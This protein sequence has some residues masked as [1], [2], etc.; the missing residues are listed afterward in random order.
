MTIGCQQWSENT[1]RL[2]WTAIL[3]T[4][5]HYWTWWWLTALLSTSIVV[6]STWSY[7]ICILLFRW[8]FTKVHC[9]LQNK[10]RYTFFYILDMVQAGWCRLWGICSDS[11][12][13]KKLQYICFCVSHGFF[14]DHLLHILPSA[15]D[16]ATSLPR[17]TL[18]V[19]NKYTATTQQEVSQK[20]F[21]LT[22]FAFLSYLNLITAFIRISWS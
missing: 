13:R 8:I 14:T 10:R 16:P 11:V 1:G 3:I 18:L 15:R 6:K 2:W 7:I 5:F 4:S 9:R 20:W 22:F 19:R 21:L 17:L 12:I